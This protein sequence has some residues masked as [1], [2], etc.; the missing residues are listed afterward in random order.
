[1]GSLT[2]SLL[3]GCFDMIVKG[4]FFERDA[5]DRRVADSVDRGCAMSVAQITAG[6][7][8]ISS[9]AIL[10]DHKRSR[11]SEF[12]PFDAPRS[13]DMVSRFWSGVASPEVI[14]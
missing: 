9:I 11:A 7:A 13:A 10:S 2:A 3:G 5:G 8:S 14:R 4:E 12:W 6:A 1:M